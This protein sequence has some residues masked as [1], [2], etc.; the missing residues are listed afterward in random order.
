M[1]VK[2][3]IRL[4]VVGGTVATVVGVP[5]V[6][7]AGPDRVAAVFDQA[8]T[9][10]NNKID[11]AV[12]DPIAI[13]AQLRDLEAEYPERIAEVRADITDLDQQISDIERE[14]AVSQRVVSLADEDL[15][16]L[17]TL[18]TRARERQADSDGFAVV[19]V[20][21]DDRSM[22]LDEAYASANEISGLRSAY[23]TRAADLER[24]LTLLGEQRDRL[25]QVL[26]Q[27]ETE[28]ADFQSQLWGLDR[29]VD[30]IARNDRMIE[31]LESRNEHIEKLD[32]YEAKTLDHVTAKI[33]KKLAE[34]EGRI[35]SLNTQD[36]NAS[37]VNRAKAD[38]DYT[39][40]AGREIR[41]G[42]TRGVVELENPVIEI[43][44]DGE[45]T[46]ADADSEPVA[47]R[48]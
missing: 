4:A 31:L 14:L 46:V 6:F 15:G 47:S 30:A 33:N 11:Q 3:I 42:V 2:S 34:Q 37:Y 7:V 45:K 1:V 10:I 20:R 12:G 25:G 17:D 19:R 16:Q 39:I 38:L 44:P 21:F 5:A 35:A 8:K 43:T 41:T 26:T 9:S 27:L 29:Q 24:D 36:A 18:L 32:R 40:R 48:R 13:R 23:S 22:S 28:R